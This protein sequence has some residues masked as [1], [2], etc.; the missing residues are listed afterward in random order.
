MEVTA[1]IIDDEKGEACC[2]CRH[3][4]VMVME[5]V[6]MLSVWMII[7]LCSLKH[8]VEGCVSTVV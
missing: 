8:Y 4:A 5:N 2:S 3:A 6:Y 7:Q 1:T